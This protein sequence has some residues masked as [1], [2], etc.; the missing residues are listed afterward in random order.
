MNTYILKISLADTKI[1]TTPLS[2]LFVRLQNILANPH[3][4]K[5]Q[6][7]N[8]L[9]K[10]NVFKHSSLK[11]KQLHIAEIVDEIESEWPQNKSKNSKEFKFYVQ[12]KVENRLSIVKDCFKSH[13]VF[14]VLQGRVG[15][16]KSSV[17]EIK[18]TQVSFDANQHGTTVL[19]HL[20]VPSEACFEFVSDTNEKISQLKDQFRL[21]DCRQLQKDDGK[22]IL[23][24]LQGEVPN[25][26][27]A[28]SS[29]QNSFKLQGYTAVASKAIASDVTAVKFE[30]AD[31]SSFKQIEVLADLRDR[32]ELIGKEGA[33][34]IFLELHLQC[35]LKIQ[36]NAKEKNTS[37][38]P[39]WQRDYNAKGRV[40][41]FGPKLHA[42]TAEKV[43]KH[44]IQLPRGIGWKGSGNLEEQ[45]W[46]NL[47]ERYRVIF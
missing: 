17:E 9:L 11:Q 33:T 35:A 1:D 12:K 37:G 6:K 40:T 31:R 10:T 38:T 34:K 4:S 39:S 5:S 28:I 27:N 22:N 14:D 46:M 41:I 45:E 26:D 29:L 20:T 30:G 19:K 43:L 21:S 36:I 15:S 42:Y 24:I 16:Q 8:G 7:I 18:T 25:V 32:L 47:I 13:P 3:Y 44:F 2:S 23:F